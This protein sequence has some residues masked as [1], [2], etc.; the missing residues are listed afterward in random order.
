MSSSNPRSLVKNELKKLPLDLKS[1][2]NKRNEI[3][4]VAGYEWW[5]DWADT[6]QNAKLCAKEI[7]DVNLIL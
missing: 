5:I 4:W 3:I 2:G 7:N 1:W 6:D